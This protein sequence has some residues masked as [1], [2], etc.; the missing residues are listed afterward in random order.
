M[1][2]EFRKTEGGRQ[3]NTSDTVLRSRNHAVGTVTESTEN[4][5]GSC[6]RTAKAREV[7]RF[8]LSSHVERWELVKSC[9]PLYSVQGRM[10]AI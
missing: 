1:V 10:D 9:F 7:E 8:T 4:E 5:K 3:T 6:Y 2:A